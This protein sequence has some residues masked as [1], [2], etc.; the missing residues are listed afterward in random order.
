MEPTNRKKP[1]V[2][3]E[4]EVTYDIYAAMPEDGNRYEVDDGVL[5]VMSPGPSMTHQLLSAELQDVINQTC[6][7]DYFIIDAP[8]DLILSEREVRQPDL[9]MVHRSRMS[10]VK[11]RGIVGAPDLVVEVLSPY[12]A[13]RD[14]LRKV[15]VYAKYGIPEY[16]IADPANGTLEQYELQGDTYAL[17]NVYQPDDPVRSE[18]IPCVSFTM[19][20]LLARIPKLED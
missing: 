17:T 20:A 16:W 10:I 2:I 8:F 11:N 15:A 3:R 5:E 1:P 18:R 6:R 7:N 14:K 9:V 19:Q 13:R 4:T 12:S